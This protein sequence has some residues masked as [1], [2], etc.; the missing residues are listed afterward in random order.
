M[1]CDVILEARWCQT[2]DGAI[3]T[4]GSLGAQFWQRYLEVFDQ[5]RVVA[6]VQS[7]LSADPN[8]SRVDG[9]G[10]SVHAVP[11]YIGPSS[12]A[13]KVLSVRRSVQRAIDADDAVI[14]RVGSQLATH[15]VS[16][17]QRRGHPYGVEVVGDPYDAYSPGAMKHP[18]RPFLRWWS[19]LRLKEQC[20]NACSAAYVTRESLQRRYH[21]APIAYTTHY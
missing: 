6:R 10:I 5:I 3:W 11:Y 2:S 16:Y 4:Q 13:R 21:P 9:P 19:P 8:W 15:A 18:L 20:A 17:L 7:V 14:L 1:R 12:Y